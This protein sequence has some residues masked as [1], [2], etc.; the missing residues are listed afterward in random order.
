MIHTMRIDPARPVGTIN[1]NIYGHF[2]EHLGHCIDGGIWV[3]P[4]SDIPNENGLRRDVLEALQRLKPPV[5]RWPGGCFA[6]YYHWRDGIGPREKRP[7]RINQHWGQEV[8]NNHFGTHE[9]M[10]FCRLLDAE[11]Y[12]SGN[13]GSGTAQEMSDW[14]EYLNAPVGTALS[15]LRRENGRAEPFFVKFFGVGN[16]AWGCGGHMSP[17]YYASQ[18]RRYSTFLIPGDGQRLCKIACGPNGD[19]PDWTQRFFEAMAQGYG[20][21]FPLFEAVQGFA[22]H[23][24]C[25]TAGTATE[26]SEDQWYELL[27]KAMRIEAMLLK[28]RAIMDE[29]DPEGKIGLIIDEWGAWHP[30]IPDTNPHFLRQQSTVRDALVAA[31]SL[32][33][34]NRHADKVAMTNIAQMVNVLQAMILT[35]GP[36]MLVTPTGYVYEMYAAHQGAE[37][38]WFDLETRDIAF[39]AADGAALV[40]QVAGSCSRNGRTL[41]VSVVNLSAVEPARFAVELNGTGATPPESW[42]VLTAGIHAHNTFANPGAVVPQHRAVPGETIE[43]PPASVNVLRFEEFQ[44]LD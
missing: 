36:E 29:F 37:S 35:D 17:E 14:L 41:T 43:L 31:L 2:A 9:F 5:V 33:I 23:Y 21:C 6:D 4:D 13:L 38:L 28:H 19:D 22:L 1:P 24:Y 15:D 32:D 20:N 40:P 30:V 42:H 7:R 34:F 39:A 16:E 26:Y 10:K 44:T 12:V 3:G 11:P 8:E 25:G 18:V 27:E